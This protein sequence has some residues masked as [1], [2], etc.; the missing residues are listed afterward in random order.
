[1]PHLY[2]SLTQDEWFMYYQKKAILIAEEQRKIREERERRRLELLANPIDQSNMFWP[3]LELIRRYEMKNVIEFEPAEGNNVCARNWL[4]KMGPEFFELDTHKR[5]WEQCKPCYDSCLAQAKDVSTWKAFFDIEKWYENE[6]NDCTKQCGTDCH[7]WEN[8]HT[9]YF[10]MDRR[11][12]YK[13]SLHSYA[14]ECNT[15]TVNK[16][17]YISVFSRIPASVRYFER[18]NRC[19]F[20]GF[21]A[22]FK[23]KKRT[24]IENSCWS[25]Y[26]RCI[27]L[28][29][30]ISWSLFVNEDLRE[31]VRPAVDRACNMHYSRE[32]SP[33]CKTYSEFI[34]DYFFRDRYP[35]EGPGPRIPQAFVQQ[36]LTRNV[37]QDLKDDVLTYGQPHYDYWFGNPNTQKNVC[38]QDIVYNFN[39]NTDAPTTVSDP[40]FNTCRSCYQKCVGFRVGYAHVFRRALLHLCLFCSCLIADHIQPW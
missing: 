27:D 2:D 1:M 34:D 8:M 4:R 26:N 39:Y 38:L 40:N 22:A 12:P 32:C 33:H 29:P 18:N 37:I 24:D 28:T 7:S 19:F 5:N 21:S 10:G 25:C 11:D 13:F 9:V 23:L 31:F 15:R 30:D 17:I 14:K 20:G 3:P 16:H 36:C 6:P 35:F